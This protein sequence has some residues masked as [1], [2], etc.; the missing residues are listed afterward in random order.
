VQFHNL[1]PNQDWEKHQY[2]HSVNKRRSVDNN[3]NNTYNRN[4]AN[5]VSVQ[6]RLK[7]AS[8]TPPLA[9]INID[10]QL[11][12]LEEMEEMMKHNQSMMS[13]EVDDMTRQMDASLAIREHPLV[14]R[15]S[16]HESRTMLTAP[17]F[18]RHVLLKPEN[19]DAEGFNNVVIT[20][21][22]KK[23]DGS[24]Y[25]WI[26]P[27]ALSQEKEEYKRSLANSYE[28]PCIP[29]IN[30][31]AEL[32]AHKTRLVLKMMN[33][34]WARMRIL[35][36][37]ED[38]VAL[39]DLDSGKKTI[40][41]VAQAQVKAALDE[42]LLRSAY[43]FK[44][45]FEN[46]DDPSMLDVGDV[47]QIK[48]TQAALYA[49]TF[50]VL[51]IAP[52]EMEMAEENK[53]PAIPQLPDRSDALQRYYVENIQVKDFHTGPAVKMMYL[54]GSK[55][56]KGLLHICEENNE[57]ITMYQSLCS[58]IAIYTKANETGYHPM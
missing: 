37:A 33:G 11:Q 39:E 10:D 35:K 30:N 52:T 4:N 47:V 18:K 48:I 55:L 8:T 9:R 38:I 58:D 41:S 42:D 25:F 15:R 20:Y 54:D 22:E 13:M 1:H 5:C 7:K 45:M 2:L 36:L 53:A 6:D 56:E 34:E 29:F 57:N 24:S 17:K 46:L 32:S 40:V 44:V 12:K 3:N 14:N 49:P 50:A 23:D 51:K 43:A 26:S 31:T 27:N 28:N 16:G 19:A 21:E